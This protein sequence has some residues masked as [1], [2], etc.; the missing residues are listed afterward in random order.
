MSF[1]MQEIADAA[2]VAVSTAHRYIAKLKAKNKFKK[3]SVGKLLNDKDGKKISELLGFDYSK[4]EK[5][6]SK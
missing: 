3:T 1:T 2:G 6:K 4:L 5:Q